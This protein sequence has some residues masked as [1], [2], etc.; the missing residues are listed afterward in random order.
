MFFFCVTEISFYFFFFQAE[1]GIRDPLVTGV[2]T[3]ALPI[4]GFARARRLPRR[5]QVLVAPGVADRR[6]TTLVPELHGPGQQRA[7]HRRP[8]QSRH[9]CRGKVDRSARRS[10]CLPIEVLMERELPRAPSNRQLR[11]IVAGA[12]SFP[13]VRRGLYRHLRGPRLAARATRTSQ[14]PSSPEGSG[15]HSLPRARRGDPPGPTALFAQPPG[16]RPRAV[17]LRPATGAQGRAYL[18][19]GAYLRGRD[20]RAQRSC[21]RAR[22]QSRYPFN[23]RDRAG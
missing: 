18:L 7:L 16:T 11:S 20:Q 2:Q 8:Y 10:S 9:P 6:E 15:N 22:I 14:R 12:S 3:C 4:S 5:N 23:G 21:L 1:D 19:L 13:R 17:S